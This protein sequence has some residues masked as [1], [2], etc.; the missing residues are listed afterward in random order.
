MSEDSTRYNWEVHGPVDM[1]NAEEF[2]CGLLD[3]MV[4]YFFSCFSCEVLF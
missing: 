4:I 2:S 1:G 3:F